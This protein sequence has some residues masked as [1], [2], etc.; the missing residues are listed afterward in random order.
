MFKVISTA[1][2]VFLP[3]SVN[4]QQSCHPYE[5]VALLM[6]NTGAVLFMSARSSMPNGVTEVWVRPDNDEW[7]AVKIS[8]AGVACLVD[9]GSQLTVGKHLGSGVEG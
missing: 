1:L 8:P 4:A 5:K 7:V 2:A 3:L 9:G 6:V